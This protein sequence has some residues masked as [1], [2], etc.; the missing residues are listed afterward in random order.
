MYEPNFSN[1]NAAC[2]YYASA[3][4]QT[5][6]NLKYYIIYKYI[7]FGNVEGN[8]MYSCVMEKRAY[9]FDARTC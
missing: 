6:F 5:Q 3:P 8:V 9:T 2:Q 7:I 4:P 1:C